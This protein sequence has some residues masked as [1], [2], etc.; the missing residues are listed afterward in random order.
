MNNQNNRFRLA[1]E[2][3]VFAAAV[4]GTLPPTP[5][6]DDLRIARKSIETMWEYAKRLDDDGCDVVAEC[7]KLV[8]RAHDEVRGGAK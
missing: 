2:N 7:V 6:N 5:G 3:E 4:N 8:N 1:D